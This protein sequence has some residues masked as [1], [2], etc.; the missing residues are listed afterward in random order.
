MPRKRDSGSLLK[1]TRH[2]TFFCFVGFYFLSVVVFI[3][4]F[5]V[6]SVVEKSG[7][8]PKSFIRVSPCF[9]SFV[10][11]L[12]VFLPWREKEI[13]LVDC[14]GEKARSVSFLAHLSG[15]NRKRK[16]KTQKGRLPMEK[17]TRWKRTLRWLRWSGKKDSI[18]KNGRKTISLI[19]S[20]KT[21]PRTRLGQKKN[22]DRTKQKNESKKTRINNNKKGARR[23]FTRHRSIDTRGPADVKPGQATFPPF[24]FLTLWTWKRRWLFV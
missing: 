20:D 16:Q 11:F 15:R 13:P 21:G 14:G 19:Y 18:R 7:S 5:V 10:L 2:P 24:R 1:K 9:S 8:R 23:E 22:L 4:C 3:F 12:S 6:G 17:R